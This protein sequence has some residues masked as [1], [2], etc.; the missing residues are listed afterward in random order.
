MPSNTL[1]SPIVDAFE[2]VIDA[3]VANSDDSGETRPATVTRID[4]NGLTWVH[5][6]GGVSE[7]PVNG[8]MVAKASPKDDVLVSIRNGRC[9]LVG[10]VTRP[11]TDD[12]EAI[13][14]KAAASRAAKAAEQSAV[15]ASNVAGAL[16]GEV[17]LRKIQDGQ[18]REHST[19][20][21]QTESE[22]KLQAN[23][24]TSIS[25]KLA[26]AEASIKVNADAIE[27]KANKTI[28]NTI[29]GEQV[30]LE[31]F[32]NQNAA[33][34]GSTVTKVESVGNSLNDF[35][36]L[37]GAENENLQNQID[38]SISTWFYEG[39]P[40]PND[41]ATPGVS[42]ADDPNAPA[43]EWET[44]EERNVHL[45][46]LYYDT[47]TGYCY[48]WMRNS[49]GV[50]YW[51]R[52]TD[53]DLQVAIDT[54]NRKR[55]IFVKEPTT[56][57]QIGDL[58]FRKNETG[59]TD[60]YICAVG[61]TSSEPFSESDWEKVDSKDLDEFKKE[62]TSK[63][64][65]TN[66]SITATVTRIEDD[67]KVWSKTTQ[68]VAGWTFEVMDEDGNVTQTLIDGGQIHTGSITAD[69]I[70]AGTITGDK[71]AGGTITADNIESGAITTDKLDAEAITA[72]KIAANAIKAIHISAQSITGDKI[73]A[74]AITSDQIDT[75]TLKSQFLEADFANFKAIEATTAN[76]WKL[77]SY[78]GIVNELD[79]AEGN[80]THELNAV[81]IN[82]DLIRA[83]TITANKVNIVGEDGIIRQIN[84]EGMRVL[85]PESGEARDI[86]NSLN[87]Q[88]LLAKSVTA[89]RISVTD[90]TAFDAT[91]AGI[92]M[93]SPRVATGE[94]GEEIRIP[95]KLHTSV[96]DSVLNT[97][98]GY[99]M[100]SNGNFSLGNDQK[101]IRF[102]NPDD[103]NGTPTDLEMK[104]TRLSLESG[105]L[106][107]SEE[108]A[109][110]LTQDSEGLKLSFEK[111]IDKGEG[112]EIR[113]N[114]GIYMTHSGDQASI[115][116]WADMEN[117]AN[118][119]P[120]F[121]I[122]GNKVHMNNGMSF[123][124]LDIGRWRWSEKAA[125]TAK[126]GPTLELRG[127]GR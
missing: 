2:K 71:I 32:V 105:D 30:D 108:L 94:S 52:V 104:I 20:I 126:H 102:Y 4:E 22:V 95:G 63:F 26:E 44:D 76:L 64:E 47:V 16:S 24:I 97:L 51:T 19:K 110:F 54:A 99:Y 46:D 66:D 28:L 78:S 13:E 8:T 120:V 96:K 70:A 35:I 91:I 38:G 114:P 84:L 115:Q 121:E 31:S 92:A 18:I 103:P 15:M 112:V 50:Y 67:K 85:D 80:F 48:R 83:N 124:E 65:Q 56:P 87:G 59:L 11:A 73:A 29:T 86:T 10:N 3:K 34:I 79:V 89:D 107:T 58:W 69:K 116:L 90:L 1:T 100:D 72:D 36:R 57:Y 88:I 45:G 119:S 109:S 55:T 117:M 93:E 14:A 101:Y 23:S 53:V 42:S 125:P 122:I 60:V 77:Y 40:Q 37:Q 127:L 17:K 106:L 21:E 98:S 33:N 123:P 113:V 61:R 49:D 81:L 27:T 6:R 25:G 62:T 43:V 118:G 39:A 12:A 41:N 68:T 82:G 7:S 75:D 74:K 5:V 111:Y 9:S